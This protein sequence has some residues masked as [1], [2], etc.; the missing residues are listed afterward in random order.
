MYTYYKVYTNL[1]LDDFSHL[2]MLLVIKSRPSSTATT[3]GETL[4]ALRPFNSRPAFGKH[5]QLEI[6]GQVHLI[7]TPQ[8]R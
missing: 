6:E 1:P 5:S 4:V 8:T 7:S 2:E 3:K